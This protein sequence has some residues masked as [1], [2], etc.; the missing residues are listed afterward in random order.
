M[1]VI[2][3]RGSVW[4]IEV[5]EFPYGTMVKL[6]FWGKSLKITNS[7]LK[8]SPTPFGEDHWEENSGK[9]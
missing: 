7:K 9:V 8:K 6:E 2:C 4:T 5:F 1:L 3:R